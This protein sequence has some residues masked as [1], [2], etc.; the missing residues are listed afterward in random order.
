MAAHLILT[1]NTLDT[2]ICAK[3]RLIDYQ[4][5]WSV[6]TIILPVIMTRF[7][8]PWATD[9]GGYHKKLTAIWKLGYNVTI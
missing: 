7:M 4:F 2:E 3:Y 8:V 9:A 5:P 6:S 1:N